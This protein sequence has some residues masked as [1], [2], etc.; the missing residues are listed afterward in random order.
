[1]NEAMFFA[2]VDAIEDHS[3]KPSFS[4][5]SK[6]KIW[7]LGAF[8]VPKETHEVLAW[9]F[10]MIP[11]ITEVI[12]AQLEGEKLEVEGIGTFDV[13][14]HLGGD[15]KTIKCILGCKQACSMQK[16]LKLQKMRQEEH[17]VDLKGHLKKRRLRMHLLLIQSP[18]VGEKSFS[19][20][21]HAMFPIRPS[22]NNG[23]LL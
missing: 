16:I 6:K 7:W 1:M 2:K 13:E 11:W 8:E 19:R 5:Q 23:L 9:V 12:K 21:V 17:K 3:Q 4:V 22:L 14:W 10:S 18:L 15:L 20:F